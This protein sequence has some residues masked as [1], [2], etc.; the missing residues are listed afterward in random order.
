V[1]IDGEP[2][3]TRLVLV[4]SNAYELSLFSLGERASLTDGLLHLYTAR[5]W[6]PREWKERSAP[7]FTLDA[8]EKA[9]PGALDGEPVVLEPPVELE[10]APRAL[11]VLVPKRG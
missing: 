7:R 2:V 11:R 10:I 1:T 8:A 6:V 9:L 4:A 5:G 3:T